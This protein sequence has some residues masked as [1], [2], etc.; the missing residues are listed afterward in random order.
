MYFSQ[1]ESSKCSFIFM[2]SHLG[3]PFNII[4]WTQFCESGQRTDIRYF[5]GHFF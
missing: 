1:T 4:V 3:Q 5:E 2:S